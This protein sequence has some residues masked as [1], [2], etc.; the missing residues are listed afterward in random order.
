MLKIIA[1][2]RL[3]QRSVI[4][5]MYSGVPAMASLCQERTRM[6]PAFA[7]GIAHR[8]EQRVRTGSVEKGQ[9]DILM[10]RGDREAA[11]PL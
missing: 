8:G 4:L 2:P 10:N 6:A 9:P 11:G 1:S 5:R 7:L 3:P